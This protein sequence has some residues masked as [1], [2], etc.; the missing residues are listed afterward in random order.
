[1]DDIFK[2]VKA[3]LV[4]PDSEKFWHEYL[5]EKEFTLCSSVAEGFWNLIGI[6]GEEK[7]NE[8]LKWVWKNE[9]EH[10]YETFEDMKGEID[11]GNDGFGFESNEIEVIEFLLGY[12]F[13]KR[14]TIKPEV[15]N[16]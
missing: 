8:F 14:E 1:M 11:C 4:K 9:I 2:I 16:T 10:E 3:K 6:S 7:C 13:D 5:I 12:D 15:T